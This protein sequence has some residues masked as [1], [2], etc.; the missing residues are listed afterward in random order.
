MDSPNTLFLKKK[1][2]CSVLYTIQCTVLDD[3]LNGLKERLSQE[4]LSLINAIGNLVQFNLN[5]Q[6]ITLLS[7]MFNLKYNELEVEFGLLKSFTEIKICTT[8]KTVYEWINKLSTNSLFNSF[9][10]IYKILTLSVTMS[11]TSCS[12]EQSFSKL[13]LVKTKLRSCMIQDRL[14]T[15]MLIFVKQQLVVELD[16]DDIIEEFNH[17]NNTECRL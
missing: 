8:N 16:P 7:N 1:P 3:L 12:C 2:K 11:V 4:T 13:N 9:P 15:M 5:Q 10:S 14:E 17:L 6:N